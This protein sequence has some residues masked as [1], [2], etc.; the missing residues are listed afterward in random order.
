MIA[1][2]QLKDDCELIILKAKLIA[3]A[4]EKL[5]TNVK[6]NSAADYG[7]FK[8]LL[9]E[10]FQLK[11][12]F[13]EIQNKFFTLKQKPSQTVEE[14]I[15]EFN[16]IV[17]AYISKNTEEGQNGSTKFIDLIKLTRFLDSLKADLS[18]DVRKN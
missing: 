2:T 4:R 18:L 6:L 1:Q 9:I 14:F 3:N 16:E 15:T 7:E 12:K 11:A 8:Q 10:C 13:S 17:K 5:A